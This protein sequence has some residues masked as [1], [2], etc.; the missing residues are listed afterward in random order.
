MFVKKRFWCLL[1]A[2]FVC[3]FISAQTTTFSNSSRIT[4]SDGR[5]YAQL[6]SVEL[7]DDYTFVTIGL[8]VTKPMSRLNYWTGGKLYTFLVVDDFKINLL[9]ALSSDGK[10]YHSCLPSD[11]WGWDKVE[12][13]LGIRISRFMTTA[14]QQGMVSHSIIIPSIIRAPIQRTTQS[15]R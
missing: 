13:R 11:G 14:G 8:T 9:G 10:T 4:S 3:F 12:Y 2:F 6:K 7:R 1:L 5:Y 15:I